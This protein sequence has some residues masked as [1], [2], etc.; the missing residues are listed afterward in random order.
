MCTSAWDFGVRIAVGARPRDVV[1]MVMRQG[2]TLT[3][4][5]MV[6]RLAGA[7]ALTRLMT[8]MRFGV[9]A[10]DRVTYAAAAL[11]LFG[12]AG[13]ASWIPVRRAASIDPLVARR[14]E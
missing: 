11:A 14:S 9:G 8:S 5:S 7:V 4:T 13:F 1:R 10:L 2:V 6:V 3:A 12:V